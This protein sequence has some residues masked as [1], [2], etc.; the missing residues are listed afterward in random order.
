MLIKT[1]C[2]LFLFA[3]FV[4][5]TKQILTDNHS[6]LLPNYELSQDLHDKQIE[7]LE[8]KY[9]GSLRC[10]RAATIIQRAYRQYK[11]KE[12]FRHLCAT[13]KTNRRLSCTLID[14][15]KSMKKPLKPC[16]RLPKTIDHHLDLPS[17]NFEHFIE[18]SKQQ[19]NLSNNRKRVCI[20]TDE[21]IVKN[22]YDQM[23]NFSD[24]TDGKQIETNHFNFYE[25][26]TNSPMESRKVT[27]P[28][29]KALTMIDKTYFINRIN[30]TLLLN[31]EVNTWTEKNRN[32]YSYCIT[33]IR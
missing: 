29:G 31:R 15:T 1:I 3:R 18:T 12:N 26:L 4:Q 25:N 14:N 20:I 11:L 2:N 30:L 17:I 22:V 23:E 27:T 28:S 7:I 21:P 8:R 33:S 32:L 16:L 24:F 5:N 19:E 6:I 13:M 9:G 10:R